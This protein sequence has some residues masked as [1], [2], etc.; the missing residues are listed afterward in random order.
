[1][2]K[3]DY[4]LWITFQQHFLP[5]LCES[6]VTNHKLII[7]VLR[8][9]LCGPAYWAKFPKLV[10]IIAYSMQKD[11]CKKNVSCNDFSTKYGRGPATPFR[12]LTKNSLLEAKGIMEKYSSVF[13]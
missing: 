12:W 1:M 8:T 7:I 6:W 11:L 3:L 5:S 4:H 10:W 2:V 13:L 9:L